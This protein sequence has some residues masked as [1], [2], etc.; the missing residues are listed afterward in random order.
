MEFKLSGSYID[1]RFFAPRPAR[2]TYP[3][4]PSPA[5]WWDASNTS[6]VDTVWN[7]TFSVEEVTE[8]RD[9][10]P[11][12]YT[13]YSQAP[14]YD[15]PT[16]TGLGNQINGLNGMR[17]VGGDWLETATFATAITQPFTVACYF[18]WQF[19]GIP[20]QN[21][22]DGIAA[23]PNRATL[24]KQSTTSGKIA[25]YAGMTLASSVVPATNDYSLVVGVFNGA[26]SKIRVDGAETT[27]N[28]GIAGLTGFSFGQKYDHTAS[29]YFLLG[30]LIVFDRELSSGTIA[31]I[32]SYLT[33]KWS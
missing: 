26:S 16:Y 23:H 33:D 6:T 14:T 10:G 1:P 15:P 22:W 21:I 30:E 19:V 28:A 17:F 18:Q 27:G 3:F 11:N 8:F 2:T 4:S 7:A 32:E 9:G 20:Q 12:G 31:G 24:F 25:I 29:G 5:A 13:L